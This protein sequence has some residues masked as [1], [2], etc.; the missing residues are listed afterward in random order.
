MTSLLE[1]IAFIFIEFCSFNFS[2]IVRAALIQML[3][4][5]NCDVVFN[6]VPKHYAES[7]IY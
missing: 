1:E 2:I 4:A 5:E 6:Q 3:G 7:E